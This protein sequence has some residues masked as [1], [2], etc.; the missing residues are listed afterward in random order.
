MSVDVLTEP[1]SPSPASFAI[2][3]HPDRRTDWV[4]LIA[5]R[6]SHPVPGFAAICNERLERINELAPIVGARLDKGLWSP[7]EPPR[8]IE[9][10]GNLLDAPELLE[11][12][13][14]SSDPPMRVV[15]EED[16]GHIA[17]V[18]HHAA[19]DGRGIVALLDALAGGSASDLDAGVEDRAESAG[20]APDHLTALRRMLR[21]A[22]RVPPSPNPPPRDSLAVRTL[23][24]NDRVVVAQI[25][26]AAIA[27]IAERCRELGEPWRRVGLSIP[28]GSSVTGID[29]LAT[30]RR[31]DLA[32]SDCSPE[33]I[34]AAIS[35]AI[36]TGPTP[37]EFKRASRA[38]RLLS[39]ISDRFSDS[40]LISNHGQYELTGISQLEVF[41][42]AR[43]RS[44]VVLGAA[45]VEGG[46]STLSLRARD[47]TPQ[48]AEGL[49]DRI[50]THLGGQ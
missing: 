8:A 27:A 14:L 30:Y 9:V 35:A 4:Q 19:V 26:T 6:L 2:F 45:R 28:V 43:G 5:A 40:V 23:R 32:A 20:S 38:M 34:R 3:H 31:V 17:L 25:A 42:V 41:P 13:R 39:P 47:L 1:W 46:A 48:D 22:D 44:A 12:F 33:T 15:A 24:S 10:A 16:G 37:S 49:L 29:N 50:V 11:P 36:K 21:P 18:T 7:G